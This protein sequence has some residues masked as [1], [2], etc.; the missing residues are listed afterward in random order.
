[1][2]FH[3]LLQLLQDLECGG[4][5]L[6]V[7]LCLQ[8]LS[9]GK[10]QHLVD[11][12]QEM[13]ILFQTVQVLILY[14]WRKLYLVVFNSLRSHLCLRNL[15]PWIILRRDQYG[16]L[17]G[18]IP[19]FHSGFYFKQLQS[20]NAGNIQISWND[21]SFMGHFLWISLITD[22]LPLTFSSFTFFFF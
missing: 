10:Q 7:L 13:E 2:E 4:P 21:P 22:N 14:S 5:W 6:A 8:G 15:L 12:V 9:L 3:I 16:Q 19:C 20:K 18:V 17:L 11:V 1:M